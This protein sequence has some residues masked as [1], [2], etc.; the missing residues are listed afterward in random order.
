M[1]PHPFETFPYTSVLDTM[2]RCGIIDTLGKIIVP[3]KYDGIGFIR[4]NLVSL[5]QAGK[6]GAYNLSNRIE[7][8]CLYDE[9]FEFNDNNYAKIKIKNQYGL[10]NSLGKI[11]VPVIYDDV[12][13]RETSFSVVLKQNKYGVVN[14]SGKEVIPTIYDKAIGIS[15]HGLVGLKQNEKWAIFDTTGK[16]LSAF[17]YKNMNLCYIEYLIGE[18]DSSSFLINHESKPIITEHPCS[19]D[20]IDGFLSIYRNGKQGLVDSNGIEIIPFK[21]DD[22]DDKAIRDK[23]KKTCLS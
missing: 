15:S 18:E 2:D 13:N 11:V 4:R 12:M 17:K 10:I 3:T 21:Y 19:A 6:S 9:L 7:I 16:Q 20:L 22:I 8:D 14:D 23:I 5:R 1:E